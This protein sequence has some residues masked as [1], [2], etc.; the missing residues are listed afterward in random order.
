MR[1]GE[2]LLLTVSTSDGTEL[3]KYR[4]DSPPVFDSLATANG[5]GLSLKD[6]WCGAK[7]SSLDDSLVALPV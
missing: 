1:T 5:L 6:N 4:L 3:E 7:C 2:A